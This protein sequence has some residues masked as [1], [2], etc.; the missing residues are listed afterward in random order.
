MAKLSLQ[1]VCLTEPESIELLEGY[2]QLVDVLLVFGFD[3]AAVAD[4]ADY[5]YFEVD[6]GIVDSVDCS[7][8]DRNLGIQ[9]S[10][11]ESQSFAAVVDKIQSPGS[12]LDIGF[13]D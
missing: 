7:G 10:A 3:F 13:E 4:F 5:N 8:F 11:E 6:L 12:L 2:E 9:N 1:L